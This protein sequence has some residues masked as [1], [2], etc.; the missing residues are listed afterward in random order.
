MSIYAQEKQNIE[1]VFSV[2]SVCSCGF[3]AKER[4]HVLVVSHVTMSSGSSMVNPQVPGLSEG[5]G[6]GGWAID[7]PTMGEWLANR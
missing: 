4:S 5:A 3:V 7:D 6:G 1:H 2:C